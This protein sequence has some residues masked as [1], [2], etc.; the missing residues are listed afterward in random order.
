MLSWRICSCFSLVEEGER[1]T[2]GQVGGLSLHGKRQLNP[3]TS[4]WS[5]RRGSSSALSQCGGQDGVFYEP[6]PRVVLSGCLILCF[7]HTQC[8]VLS[9]CDISHTSPISISGEDSL[10][11]GWTRADAGTI[12]SPRP[13]YDPKRV[14]LVKRVTR[15]VTGPLIPK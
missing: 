13:A 5:L 1:R 2:E 9:L 15:M 6:V 12:P 4:P 14:P 8:D 7:Y 11:C 3:V 10:G